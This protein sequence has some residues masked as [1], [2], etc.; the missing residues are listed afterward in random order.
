MVGGPALAV[1]GDG[2]RACLGHSPTIAG[3]GCFFSFPV[4]V[5]ILVF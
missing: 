2:W 5:I 3:R 1:A 4:I